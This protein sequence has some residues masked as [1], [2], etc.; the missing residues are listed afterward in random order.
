[1]TYAHFG[2]LKF[3]KRR[4]NTCQGNLAI[5]FFMLCIFYLLKCLLIMIWSV[6]KCTVFSLFCFALFWQRKRKSKTEHFLE[7][8]DLRMIYICIH[9]H[10]CV[11]SNKWYIQLIERRAYSNRLY[12]LNYGFSKRWIII[13]WVHLSCKIKATRSVNLLWLFS[14]F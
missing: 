11:K 7:F 10:F 13:K 9:N 2:P 12:I 6:K 1:M 14:L 5:M 8:C 3:L 4:F